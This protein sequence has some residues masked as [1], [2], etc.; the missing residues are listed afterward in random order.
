MVQNSPVLRV[1]KFEEM[2][3]TFNVCVADLVVNKEMT[4]PEAAS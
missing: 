3:L 1:I 2:S 4:T